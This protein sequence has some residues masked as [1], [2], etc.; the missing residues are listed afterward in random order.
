[1]VPSSSRPDRK[2]PVAAPAERIVR[3]AGTE[4]NVRPRPEQEAR[5]IDI[6]DEGTA[7]ELVGPVIKG[8]WVKVSRHGEVLGYVSV[9]FL[10][11]HP[12]K[13]H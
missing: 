7:V 6:L 2:P 13:P 4:I 12:P 8:K 1:M 3:Y 9:E 10:L 5:R 11:P